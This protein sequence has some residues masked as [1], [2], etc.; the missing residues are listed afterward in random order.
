MLLLPYMN[1]RMVQIYK[2]KYNPEIADISK[3]DSFIPYPEDVR[4]EREPSKEFLNNF[5]QGAQFTP[6]ES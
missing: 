4:V 5:I 2:Q 3:K 1:V 6:D